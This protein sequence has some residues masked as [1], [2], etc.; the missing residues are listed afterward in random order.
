MEERRVPQSGVRG[1]AP[2]A[3]QP[4]PLKPPPLGKNTF[5]LEEMYDRSPEQASFCK[6]LFATNQ[7]KIGAPY[8]PLPLEGHALLF[9][10][11][12]VGGNCRGVSIDPSLGLL[13]FNHMHRGQR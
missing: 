2:S 1:E 4:F 7:M 13:F 6:E 11:T 3:P 10:S 9:P 5:R 8:T 12:L